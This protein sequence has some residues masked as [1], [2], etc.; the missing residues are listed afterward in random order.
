[1]P[2]PTMLETGEGNRYVC[3]DETC[4]ALRC[5]ELILT[6]RG[7]S[8]NIAYLIESVENESHPQRLRK[9]VFLWV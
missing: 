4:Q 3:Y 8:G 5:M 7:N 9:I 2:E 6:A 1:M